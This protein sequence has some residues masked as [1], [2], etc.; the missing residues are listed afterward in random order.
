MSGAAMTLLNVSS[1]SSSSAAHR[2]PPACLQRRAHKIAPVRR[3]FFKTHPADD[4]FLRQCTQEAVGDLRCSQSG[5]GGLGD[6]TSDN[7]LS[8]CRILGRVT[9]T[10]PHPFGV[11]T[12][13]TVRW[14]KGSVVLHE[15]FFRWRKAGASRSTS[16]R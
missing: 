6:L 15:R 16:S 9:W 12:T 13:R 2:L 10:S 1:T 7:P 11:G 4:A 14:L 5:I 3:P 8:W